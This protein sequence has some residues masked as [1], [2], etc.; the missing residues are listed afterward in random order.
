MKQAPVKINWIDRAVQVYNYHVSQVKDDP[1]WTLEKTANSLNRSIGSVSQDM[2]IANWC[3]THEKRLRKFRSM[4]DAL[5]FIRDKKRENLQE[6][7]L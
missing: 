7:N 3:K 2:L 1:D 5:E 6:I 4:K